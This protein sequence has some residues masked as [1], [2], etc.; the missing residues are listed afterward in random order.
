MSSELECSSFAVTREYEAL[1][2]TWRD[3]RYPTHLSKKGQAQYLGGIQ[4]VGLIQQ[5]EVADYRCVLEGFMPARL[6]QVTI[7]NNSDFP[8][9]WLDDGRDHGEWQDPWY[10]SN[11]NN[12]K[13]GERGTFRLESSGIATGVDGWALFKIDVPLV[14]NLGVQTEFL[15]LGFSRAYIGHFKKQAQVKLSNGDAPPHSGP[16]WTFVND[17]GFG[18]I[19]NMDSSPFE[20]LVGIPGAPLT[21]PTLLTNDAN[22]KH[23]AWGVEVR[24][25]DVNRSVLPLTVP[26][27]GVKN[28]ILWH[29]SSTGETQIWFMDGQRVTG[30]ATVLGEDGSATFIGPPFSIVGAGDFNGDGKADIL[31]HNSSTGETQIWFMDGQKVTGRATVLGEDGSATFIGPPFSIVGAGD[32]NGDR[33]ADILW[34]NRST[35][36]TQIWFMDG[37]RVTGRATVLGEDGSATFIGPPFSIVGTGDFNGHGKADILWHNSSTGETQIWFMD[38]QRVTGRA[39]VLGEDG[40]AT[41]IGPPFSIVGAGDFNGDGKADILWHNSS[42]GETQI[43]L[44][45]GPRVTGRATVLGEDGNATFIGPPFSIVGTGPFFSPRIT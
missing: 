38:G 8:I 34:H 18:D 39:T 22:A 35:G 7:I 20:F 43:W 2:P 4:S 45:D 23:V 21:A 13:K 24:N 42:T 41:F 28:D 36:E 40:S 6:V 32:F 33:K 5:N 29:N 12:L 25:V 26:A 44:M 10:P 16:A 1:L 15:N 30:R 14:P 9:I 37:Q 11:I 27:T 19:A 17:I 3:T 31:W